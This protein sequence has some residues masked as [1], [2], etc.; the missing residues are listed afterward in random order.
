MPSRF[1]PLKLLCLMFHIHEW[2]HWQQIAHIGNNT[3]LY[4]RTCQ[5]C[6]AGESYFVDVPYS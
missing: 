1:S 2:G 3:W 6:G 4:Q 5:R